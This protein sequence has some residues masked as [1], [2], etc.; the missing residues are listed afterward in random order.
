M[1]LIIFWAARPADISAQLQL[2]TTLPTA[3]LVQKNQ[4]WNLVLV[5]GSTTTAVGRIEL[6]LLDRL[7]SQELMTASTAEFSVAKGSVVVNVNRVGPVSYNYIGME[8]DR[9][10][11]PL[12][13][14]G[15]YSAC[16]SF[17]RNP[18]SDKR[19]ILA[20]ECIAFDVEPLSPP[21][22]IF[23]SDS[24]VLENSPAQFTWTPPVPASM[25]SRLRYEVIITEIGNMQQPAEAI[26]E[27][28]PFF[29]TSV[30]SGNYLTYSGAQ[31]SFEKEK[32]YAWQVTAR[33]ENQYA[34]KSEVWVFKVK[35]EKPENL[36]VKGSP[37]LR[38][39][40]GN[41]ETGIAPNGILKLAYFNRSADSS[42]VVSIQEISDGGK[43]AAV[44]IPVKII[45]GENQ[46]QL[47]LQK[48][49][50]VKEGEIY[51]A[52]ITAGKERSTVLFVV[53]YFESKD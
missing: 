46:L 41:T 17:V 23:P 16:Y 51:K 29:S 21:M 11:N 5:N 25:L 52:E 19:E 2:Q 4:L 44:A 27:S 31:P 15:A 12:L 20:E 8:P 24:A 1:I 37:Y 6:V 34:G 40:T 10:I 49:I 32:W 3:G 48:F 18:D 33:D 36:L 53:K 13:P 42:A 38:V 22:L 39:G 50:T 7:T 9:T 30:L 45:T 28:N 26:E 35:G 14:A 43:Q 47:N